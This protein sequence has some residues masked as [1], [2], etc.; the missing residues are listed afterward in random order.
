MELSFFNDRTDIILFSLRE[1]M[2]YK[3]QTTFQYGRSFFY[4]Y[5]L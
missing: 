5:E 3:T 4:F 1:Y 2:F